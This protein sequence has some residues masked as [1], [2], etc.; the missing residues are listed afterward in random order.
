MICMTVY[1][2]ISF[3]NLLSCSRMPVDINTWCA[4]IRL[5]G[6]V[7]M[8]SSIFHLTK[9]FRCILY[10]ILLLL[11]TLFLLFMVHFYYKNLGLMAFL[12][13]PVNAINI[14]ESVSSK[15]SDKCCTIPHVRMF[16]CSLLFFI[17]VIFLVLSGD[18][19]TNPGP[20]LGYLDS[21][22]FCH[23]N[24]NSIVAHNFINMSLLQAYNA[25]HRS[26]I[27]CLSESYL[28]NSYH[29]D[30]Y[31]LAFPGYNLIRADNP[32]NI[33]K[34]RSLHLLSRNFTSQS[35]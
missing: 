29:S 23:W 31:Q 26:D 16:S 32:N 5:F 19:E 14:K 17:S 35:N 20:D 22:S 7:S 21:F 12:S 34:R 13:L 33:K 28:D 27:I 2:M 4:A 1:L 10:T 25:I 6:N 18:I 9:C 15:F 8:G 3:V 30:N 11:M 24:L